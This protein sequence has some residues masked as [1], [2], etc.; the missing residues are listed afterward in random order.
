MAAMIVVYGTPTDAAEFERYYSEKHIPYATDR[1]P[2]VTGAQN[3]AVSET[4]R[5]DRDCYRS[6]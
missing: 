6:R 3:F 4:K 2:D 5:G 1:T